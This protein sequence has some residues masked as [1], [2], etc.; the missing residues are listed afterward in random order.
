MSWEGCDWVWNY[1]LDDWEKVANPI[2]SD[3]ENQA[4]KTDPLFGENNKWDF[5]NMGADNIIREAG[6]NSGAVTFSTFL[7]KG[8]V[9]TFYPIKA[10]PWRSY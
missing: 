7:S 1:A 5:S 6:T 2:E 8:V 10:T 3:T 4:G 9:L